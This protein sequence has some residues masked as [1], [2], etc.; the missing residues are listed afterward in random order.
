MNVIEINNLEKI[1]GSDTRA[2][3]GISFTVDSG[4][5]VGLLGPNG[6]GKTTTIDMILGTLEP[7]SGQIKIFGKDVKKERF[8]ISKNINFAAVYAHVPSNLTVWQNLYVFGLLYEVKDLRKKMEFLI[9][10]FEL[11]NFVGSKAGLLSS[12][13]A[14]RLNIAKAVI[15]DPK[16]LLLDEPTSSLDPDVSQVVRQKIK[17]YAKEK[18]MAILWTSHNMREIE[19]VCDKVYFLSHGKIITSGDPKTLAQKHQKHDLEELFISI[20][21]EPLSFKDDI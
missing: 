9:K 12:G 21:R 20:A 1:Y 14:T 17:R 13:E 19:E 8:E 4:E 2:V 10:D 7:T 11:E 16:L 18:N 15:N 6:A 5:I 3:G